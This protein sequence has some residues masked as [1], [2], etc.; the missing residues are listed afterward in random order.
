LKFLLSNPAGL[1]ALLAV[2]VILLIHM[3]QERARRVRVSTLF[4][5]ERVKPESIGGSRLEKLRN[6]LPLWLQILAVLVLTWLLCEP[7][8]IRQDARQTIVVVLDSS[9]SMAAF[10]EET[11]HMLAEKL[12]PWTRGASHTDWHLLESAPRKPTLYA[13]SDLG[14][15]LD[16]IKDFEPLSGTHPPDDALQTARSLIRGNAGAV[17]FVSDHKAPV[18]EGIGLLSAGEVIDNVGFAGIDVKMVNNTPRWSVL[19][20][21]YGREPAAREWWMEAPKDSKVRIP[22][23]RR[24]LVV[25]P[26]KSVVLEGEFGEGVERFTLVMDGDRFTL[27]DRLPLQ[28]PVPR[29]VGV[30]VKLKGAAG[31]IMKKMLSALDGVEMGSLVPDLVVDELGTAVESQAVQVAVSSDDLEAGIDPAWVAAEQN[32]LTRDLAWSPLLC[33]KPTD[34]SQ[35]TNDEPLLWKDGRM[36]ALVR[37]GTKADGQPLQRLILNWDIAKSNAARLP[38]MLVLLQRFVERVREIRSTPWAGNFELGER[39][40]VADLGPGN[41]PREIQMRTADAREAFAGAAPERPGFFEVLVDK[42]PFLSAAAH[43]ADTREADFH[44][45]APADNTGSLRRELAMK[46]TEADPFMP[47]WVLAVL[48]CLIGSWAWRNSRKSTASRSAPTALPSVLQS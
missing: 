31:E 33:G 4:L 41:K 21:N 48:G 30:T 6:S 9:A 23:T 10:K 20:K 34:L 47:L 18:P 43:F 26:G 42:K 1:W 39:F 25:E 13:G 28:R 17:I 36:L 11:R 15:L 8:W 29:K 14:A 12:H 5:L 2:P 27:D 16:A 35:D 3:L 19:V 44:D 38:A 40:R 24:R 32:P 37:K 46:Q 45:A 22:D 7:R